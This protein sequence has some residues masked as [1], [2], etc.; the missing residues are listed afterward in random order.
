MNVGS[1]GRGGTRPDDAQVFMFFNMSVLNGCYAPIHTYTH[2]HRHIKIGEAPNW[3]DHKAFMAIPSE[4]A[5][6]CALQ[7]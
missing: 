2:I 4:Q 5:K 6:N 3:T 7:R 1:I